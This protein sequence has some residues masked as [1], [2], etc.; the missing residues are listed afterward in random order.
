MIERHVVDHVATASMRSIVMIAAVA[1]IISALAT[2]AI[3]L[4]YPEVGR[5]ILD[6][7]FHIF[8]IM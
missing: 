5:A 6:V 8:T 2:A 3:A 7:L 4:G 1:G